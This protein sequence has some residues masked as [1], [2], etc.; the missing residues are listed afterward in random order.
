MIL[1]GKSPRFE[2]GI[3]HRISWGFHGTWDLSGV[4]KHGEWLDMVRYG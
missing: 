3:S 1:M 2:L 4:I